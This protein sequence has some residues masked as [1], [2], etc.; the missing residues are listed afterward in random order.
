MIYHYCRVSTKEQNLARQL[1][2]LSAYKPADKVFSDKQSGKDFSRVAYQEMKSILR[3]GDEVIVKE[4]D[5]LGRNKEEVKKELQELSAAGVT[6]RILN[7]PTTLI[8]FGSQEWIRDMVNNIIIEV[9]SSVAQ[10]ERE[11][12][13]QRQREGIDAMPIVNGVRISTKTGKTYGRPAASLSAT[14][15]FTEH[16]EAWKNGSTT[17]TEACNTLGISRSTWYKLARAC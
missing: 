6:V 15:G 4:L 16:Y 5:R 7:V 10:E 11:K 2:S 9:L 17:V 1:S 14:P 13:R 12:I 8:D 3:S